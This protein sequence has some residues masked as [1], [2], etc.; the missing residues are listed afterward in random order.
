MLWFVCYG[1]VTG[2]GGGAYKYSPGG[3]LDFGV[4]D[5]LVFFSCLSLPSY[6]RHGWL[7]AKNQILIFCVCRYICLPTGCV[8][9]KNISLYLS[10]NKALCDSCALHRAGRTW[11]G[12][13]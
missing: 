13:M 3:G 7:G 4:L 2:G 6:N 9:L 10:K 1:L 5:K 12:V 8:V 11:Y